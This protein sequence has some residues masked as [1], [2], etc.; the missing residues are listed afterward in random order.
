MRRLQYQ[1]LLD[2]HMIASHL[3]LGQ[4]WR[5]PVTWCA[6]WKGSGRACLEHL[7]EKHGGSALK[8]TINVAQFSPMDGD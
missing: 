4:L 8:I 3:E 2:P 7:A 1:N 6:V 5:C